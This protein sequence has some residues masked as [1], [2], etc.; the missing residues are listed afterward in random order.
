MKNRSGG[1]CRINPNALDLSHA[2]K[3]TLTTSRLA[4]RGFTPVDAV[5]LHRIL[6]E[7]SI[8]QYFSKT[9]AP[10]LERV[11]GLIERQLLQW[12][13]HRLGWWAVTLKSQTGLIGWNGF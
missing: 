6:S 4:L 2:R 13:E 10:D 3:T 7:P 12:Q 5:S 1:D 9:D 8:L 11:R